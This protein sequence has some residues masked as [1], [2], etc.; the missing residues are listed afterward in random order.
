[1]I[2]YN[3]PRMLTL[4]YLRDNGAVLLDDETAIA[5]SEGDYATHAMTV[6]CDVEL[7]IYNLTGKGGAVLSAMTPEQRET[8]REYARS[9][10]SK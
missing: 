3:D 5:Y 6:Q 10:V 8:F 1:M 4:C 9:L 7:K 2:Q